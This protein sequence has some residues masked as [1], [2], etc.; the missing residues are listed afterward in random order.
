LARAARVGEQFDV[1]AYAAW[2]IAAQAELVAVLQQRWP[3]RA[4][5]RVQ[6]L[7]ELIPRAAHHIEP[8]TARQ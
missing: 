4:V 7:P 1:D 3:D 5:A 6:V 8:F 2:F